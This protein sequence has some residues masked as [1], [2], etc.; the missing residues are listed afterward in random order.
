MRRLKQEKG[1]ATLF[2][3][4]A[5]LFFVMYLVGMYIYSSNAEATQLEEMQVIKETY[6]QGVNDIDDIYETLIQNNA[7]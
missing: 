3:L 4:L 5:M 1:S 7:I 6:E 2:V